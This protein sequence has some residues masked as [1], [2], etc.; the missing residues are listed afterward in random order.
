MQFYFYNT[1][2]NEDAPQI[3]NLS[4]MLQRPL[5]VGFTSSEIGEVVKGDTQSLYLFIRKS[6]A[7]NSADQY[8]YIK[9]IYI[10]ALVRPP[11]KASRGS[12]GSR[13]SK[14]SM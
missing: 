6:H 9:Y 7:S 4:G 2:A 5:V 13:R 14:L 3:L 11:K 12:N 10:A 8:T 1:V